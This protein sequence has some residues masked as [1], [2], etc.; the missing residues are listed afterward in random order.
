MIKLIVPSEESELTIIVYR[1]SFAEKYCNANGS[2]Y[3][4]ADEYDW[5]YDKFG[6]QGEAKIMKF[7]IDNGVLRDFIDDEEWHTRII[8]P[9]GVRVI[10]EA[11]FADCMSL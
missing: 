4:L 11:A 9:D 3:I 2:D 6:I 10:G 7:C 5:P 1:V 8:I